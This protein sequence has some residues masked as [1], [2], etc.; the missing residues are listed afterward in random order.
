V[1]ATGKG[2][3]EFIKNDGHK[4]FLD[5]RWSPKQ[6]NQADGYFGI[7]QYLTLSDTSDLATLLT[8][9]VQELTTVLKAD[10]HLESRLK[11]AVRD[12]IHAT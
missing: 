6:D 9:M 7:V 8:G 11:L 3:A 4:A 1:R 10:Q 2:L 12:S 5:C